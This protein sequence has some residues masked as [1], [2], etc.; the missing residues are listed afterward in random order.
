MHTPTKSISTPVKA[1][2]PNF[3]I[4]KIKGKIAN[5]I[6]AAFKKSGLKH[7]R[8]QPIQR[9]NRKDQEQAAQHTAEWFD[10][11]IDIRNMNREHR[12]VSQNQSEVLDYST[13]TDAR[14]AGG[15]G[16]ERT[17]QAGFKS[18]NLM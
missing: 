4:N 9:N 11:H 10:S 18:V 2:S 17:T 1:V 7:Q 3:V 15:A 5:K 12:N 8:A 16:S 14:V 6:N 13:R